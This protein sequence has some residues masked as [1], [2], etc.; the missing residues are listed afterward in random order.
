MVIVVEFVTLK[1]KTKMSIAIEL[2]I[3]SIQERSPLWDQSNKQYIDFSA[4]AGRFHLARRHIA[5]PGPALVCN[6]HSSW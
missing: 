4:N 5:F 2:L 3:G 6:K 1:N